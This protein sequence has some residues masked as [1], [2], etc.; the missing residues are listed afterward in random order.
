MH[1]EELL[2]D[3]KRAELIESKDSEL[4]ESKDLNPGGRGFVSPVSIPVLGC[5]GDGKKCMLVAAQAEAQT[6][7]RSGWVRTNMSDGRARLLRL[8][9]HRV[10]RHHGLDAFLLLGVEGEG[11]RFDEERSCLKV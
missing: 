8:F 9:E 3:F 2:G 6:E 10:L 7:L 5:A 4:I 11:K 1:V